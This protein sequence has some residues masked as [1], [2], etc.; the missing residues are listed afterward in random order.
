MKYDWIEKAMENGAVMTTSR[1]VHGIV[2]TMHWHRLNESVRGDHHATLPDA[3]NSL[4]SAMEDDAAE[5]SPL[6]NS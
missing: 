6:A 2:A 4:N 1:N 5:R 3:L